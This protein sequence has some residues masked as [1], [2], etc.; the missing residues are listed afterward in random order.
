MNEFTFIYSSS[1]FHHRYKFRVLN[2]AVKDFKTSQIYR[3]L[4]KDG[5]VGFQRVHVKHAELG[6]QRSNCGSGEKK[7]I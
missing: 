1:C 5:E 4:F 7:M 2:A 3:V 6:G